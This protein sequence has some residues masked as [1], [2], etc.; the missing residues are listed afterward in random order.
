M[1][2]HQS[3]LIGYQACPPTAIKVVAGL[4]ITD[5]LVC[6][7]RSEERILVLMSRHD[8]PKRSS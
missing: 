7:R 4:E 6:D 3:L 1:D 5:I 2:M 8:F